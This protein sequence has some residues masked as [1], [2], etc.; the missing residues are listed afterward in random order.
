[1]AGKARFPHGYKQHCNLKWKEWLNQFNLAFAEV[2]IQNS[3]L[4]MDQEQQLQYIAS[5]LSD[6]V[7]NKYSSKSSLVTRPQFY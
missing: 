5:N 4:V 3:I 1:M 2:V 7:L 6:I